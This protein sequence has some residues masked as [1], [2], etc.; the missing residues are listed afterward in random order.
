MTCGSVA[1][2]QRKRSG[3]GR[4][5]Q[6]WNILWA[7]FPLIF[8]YCSSALYNVVVKAFV[9]L[10]SMQGS[11]MMLVLPKITKGGHERDIIIS[12]MS[13]LQ[14]YICQICIV[15]KASFFL[16]VVKSSLFLTE[17]LD[18]ADTCKLPYVTRHSHSKTFLICLQ[19]RPA[20]IKTDQCHNRHFCHGRIS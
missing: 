19:R 8:L 17:F 13:R 11:L 18:R 14:R 2:W 16:K 12:L 9:A 15:F 20:F 3:V 1:N 10:F 4:W 6:N 5:K 7:A